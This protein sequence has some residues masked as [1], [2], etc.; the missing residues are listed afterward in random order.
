MDRTSRKVI[1]ISLK[2]LLLIVGLIIL[3]CAA[4]MFH[5]EMKQERVYE[6]GS[7]PSM[8]VDMGMVSP[9]EPSSVPGIMMD[10]RYYNYNQNNDITDTR[11]FLKMSYSANIKTRDVPGA[12]DDVKNAVR[13]V[14]GRVDSLSSGEKRGSVSFVVSK[15]RFEE[16]KTKVESITHAKLY[17]ENISS[18]N[19][20]N[21]KQ[22]LEQQTA[23]A[24]STLA[25]LELQKQTLI[26]KHNQ[27][28]ATINSRIVGVQNELAS[29]RQ[30]MFSSQDP[31]TTNE[32]KAQEQLLIQNIASLTQDRTNENQ[33]YTAQNQNFVSQITYIKSVIENLGKQDTQFTN[34]LETVNGYINVS[35]ISWWD[36]AE[37][38]SP[39]HPLIIS[40]VL[41]LIILF[42]LYRRGYIPKVEFV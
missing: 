27:N 9:S 26:N 42:V 34:E 35:W 23:S 36:M 5:Y 15:S 11:E 10:E 29:V 7:A 1:K 22:S 30:Q 21:Q 6:I 37:K 41:I 2:K 14:E 28:L 17:T 25:T 24:T 20:L 39:I 13:D 18:Q 4:L 33:S 8:G 32:L 16:F 31:E 40:L 12:V 3:I 19:L 38:I